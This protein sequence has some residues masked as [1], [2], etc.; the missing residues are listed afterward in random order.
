MGSGCNPGSSLGDNE[1]MCLLGIWHQ[2]SAGTS[3]V[4]CYLKRLGSQ[5]NSGPLEA[6]AKV[7][8][9]FVIGV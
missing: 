8:T 1:V 7:D 3:Y 2:N 9:K 4:M 5:K 6:G